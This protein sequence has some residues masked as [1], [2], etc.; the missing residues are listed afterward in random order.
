MPLR[1]LTVRGYRSIRRVF[2]QL[3]QVNVIVG[4]N[5]CGK[6]NLY[7]SLFLLVAAADGR[8]A[9]TLAQEGGMPSALWAGERLKGTSKRIK[10]EVG[11][12]QWAYSLSCGLPMPSGSAFQLD[13]VV[14]EERLVFRHGDRRVTV[15]NRNNGSAQLRNDEGQQVQFPLSIS[16][17]E[18]IMSELREPHRY[19]ELSEL[20]EVLLAWRFYHQFRTD[21]E[22][23]LRRPQIGVRTP[24]LNHDGGDLAA[25]LQT[26]LEIGDYP[27]L[28]ASVASA[29]PA[30]R[31]RIRN[32]SGGME[33]GLEMEPFTR[34]FQASELSDGTL[35]YLC[36][37][38]GLLSPR[39]PTLLAINE[40]DANLH[41]QLY[42]PLANL[43]ANAAQHSQLWV[44]THSVAL[45]ELL[46]QRA[47]ASLIRLE[48]HK[49]ETVV[50][51]NGVEE[52]D[53]DEPDD[54][55]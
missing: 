14:R 50:A 36:L 41:P 12:D 3:G 16:D 11:F 51:G 34:C 49:G 5:G 1:S 28:H 9:R 30:G 32:S 7:R 24:A 21:A 2:L 44:T 29:F 37:L 47:N 25:A 38:A 43:I 27:T 6:S 10:I 23:P 54:P 4:P 20:R 53:D 13:P 52:C 42:E 35:K 8:L 45:A 33:V 55:E 39:P 48:K 46:E 18:S 26:I 17:S 15:C 31:L 22:S 19:P 40:P